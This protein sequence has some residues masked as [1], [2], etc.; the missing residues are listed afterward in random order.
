[1][2]H[3]GVGL[4]LLAQLFSALMNVSVRILERTGS[5][6]KP[7]QV[8]KLALTQFLE[9]SDQTKFFLQDIV[10]QNE[11]HYDSSNYLSF[12]AQGSVFSVGKTRESGV[13]SDSW[14][15]WFPRRIWPVL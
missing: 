4:M 1:M 13:I 7:L 15:G 14:R 12:L 5:Q 2:R 10:L 8:R 9:T 6:M 3:S 11:Y